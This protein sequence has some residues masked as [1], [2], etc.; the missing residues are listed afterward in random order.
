MQSYGEEAEPSGY[1][2]GKSYGNML[3]TVQEKQRGLDGWD[4]ASREGNKKKAGNYGPKHMVSWVTI[5]SD[6]LW[7]VLGRGVM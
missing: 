7:R 5:G 1:M 2:W 3:C 6:R 4:P